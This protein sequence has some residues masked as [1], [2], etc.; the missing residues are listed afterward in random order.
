MFD[1]YNSDGPLTS[2][3]RGETGPW[4]GFKP[5]PTGWGTS[6]GLCLADRGGTRPP[7]SCT[8]FPREAV[9]IWN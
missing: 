2:T 9:S 4:A 6:I 5:G 3:E 7:G 8:S 1:I